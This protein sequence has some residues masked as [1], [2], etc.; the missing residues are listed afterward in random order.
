MMSKHRS[1][2]H[3]VSSSRANTGPPPRLL[4]AL[5]FSGVAALVYEV[6]WVRLLGD[7]FGH[8]AYAILAVLA[9]FFLGVAGGSALSDRLVRRFSQLIPA[10]AAVEGGLAAM[11]LLL[12]SA[13]RVVSPI[14][15]RLA[16]MGFEG[17]GA[18][19]AR[20]GVSAAVLAAP[21]LLMGATLPLALR[22][23]AGQVGAR[24]AGALYAA[25]TIGG[26]LGAWVC[27]FVLLRY[28]G[29]SH[30]L[31]AAA[32]CNLASLV[33]VLPLA[34]GSTE[35]RLAAGVEPLKAGGV[36]PLFAV[37]LLF[38]S[39]F[40]AVSLEVLWT[41][42]LEQVLAGTVYSFATVLSV[43]LLGIAVGGW[44]YGRWLRHRAGLALFAVVEGLLGYWVLASLFVLRVMPSVLDR[45]RD[46]I[47]YGFV[48]EAIGL[49]SLLCALVLLVPALCMGV[50]FPLLLD[51]AVAKE[52]MLV[53]ANTVGSTVGPLVAGLVL[54]PVLGLRLALV[55]VGCVT[56]G[57]ALVAWMRSS[58]GRRRLV[59]LAAVAVAGVL[60]GVS[61]RAVLVPTEDGER[62]IGMR[63]D[64]AATS[65]VVEEPGPLHDRR[66]LV[67]ST[68]VLG[69]GHLPVL[70]RRQGHLPMLMHP[71][72]QRVLVLGV[73]AAN[74]LGAISLHHPK[75][76]TA[77]ELVPGVL[78]LARRYF[79]QTN[80]HVL[81][82]GRTHA[83]CADA[84][85]VVRHPGRRYDVI[86]ADL[87]HPWQ[88]GV[89]SLYSLEQFRAV[90]EGLA[91]NGV[92]C[93]WLPLHQLSRGELRVVT[94]TFLAAFPNAV[95]WLGSLDT[96]TPV[97][98]L[99]GS[100]APIRLHWSRW[101]ACMRDP[102]LRASL[103]SAGMDKPGE[104][105]A[106]YVAGRQEL[107][108]FAG[109]GPLNTLDKPSVEFEAPLALYAENEDAEKLQCLAALMQLSWAPGPPELAEGVAEAPSAAVAREDVDA[110]RWLL[111]ALLAEAE[112]NLRG[113]VTCAEHASRLARNL[114]MPVSVLVRIGLEALKAQP[115]VARDALLDALTVRPADA[116]LLCDLGMADLALHR[117]KDAM[118]AFRRALAAR[119]GLPAAVRG[120]RQARLAGG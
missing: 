31:L 47:G 73:G 98:A 56:L 67:N 70:E 27:A 14:Y 45:T 39:G 63:E 50:L 58:W 69:G 29:V 114:E 66:L 94:R 77:V 60:I 3:R 35:A 15:D 74:T 1:S 89:G 95:A 51:L 13:I 54:L 103:A 61:P 43:F 19:I 59:A 91:P 36:S 32:A 90:R 79:A 87:F 92:F 120:L 65:A 21:T 28:L 115:A 2:T 93:Q 57:V 8:T 52:G 33:L 116:E 62:L 117:P 78:D 20:L 102:V 18:T 72:P 7:L 76:L 71:S 85:R 44:V 17:L 105:A 106:E 119:P 99:F 110:G 24:S 37:A 97:L 96:D 48:Q 111:L 88:A 113:A 26:A 112:G 12:P 16:P 55:L 107:A 23:Q 108:R 75:E 100:D 64:A 80:Y 49:E 4:A 5:V 38:A 42:A 40:V 11:G 46:A 83:I 6:V 118:T 109:A 68:Y 86:V 101:A 82:D 10:Y 41:R 22:W 34:N 81:S 84:L 30:A 25:N 53:A 104:I 9:T